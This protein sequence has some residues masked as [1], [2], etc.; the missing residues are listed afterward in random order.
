[1]H[2]LHVA[3]HLAQS[4]VAVEVAALDKEL[5]EGREGLNSGA[6]EDLDLRSPPPETPEAHHR[7]ETESVL[8][9]S[10]QLIHE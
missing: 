9:L 4:V 6:P 1:M 8:S 5:P 2:V 3:L 7:D 10:V